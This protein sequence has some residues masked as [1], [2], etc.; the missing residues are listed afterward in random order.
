MPIKLLP[1]DP[2]W[3]RQA[4]LL[5][6]DLRK[7]IGKAA[8]RLEHVGSTAVPGLCAKPKLHIDILVERSV[9]LSD[10]RERL[11]TAG[12]CDLGFLHRPDEVQLTRAAGNRF[13][14]AA[15]G[16]SG[17]MLAH[18]ISL[19]HEGCGGAADRRTFRDALRQDPDLARRYEDLK[20]RLLS[21]C[22]TPPDWRYYN[23]GK[24]AF[25]AAIL[26]LKTP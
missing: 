23:G 12:Y 2:E 8:V 22:G 17:T 7:L 6:G 19:Q 9:P 18:R 1:H 13:A 3:P 10:I 26:A 5:I 4:D 20:R 21:E 15:P 14:K 25:I 24:S 11:E 16:E